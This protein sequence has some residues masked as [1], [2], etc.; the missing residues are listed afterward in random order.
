MLTADTHFKDCYLSQN[1]PQE[2]GDQYSNVISF[3][4]QQLGDFLRW[5]KEQPFYE[6]TVVV[7]SGIT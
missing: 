3:S 7:V 6:D 5:M 1:N 2:F 4:D